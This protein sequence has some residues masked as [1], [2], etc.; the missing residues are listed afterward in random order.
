MRA[1]AIGFLLVL[2][3]P[4]TAP[5][6]VSP[7]GLP[8]LSYMVHPDYP[9]EVVAFFGDLTTWGGCNEVYVPHPSAGCAVMRGEAAT[10]AFGIRW[11]GSSPLRLMPAGESFVNLIPRVAPQ[12]I[13]S[14][15]I[16]V[17]WIPGPGQERNADGSFTILPK[18]GLSF[19]IDLS[20]LARSMPAGEYTLCFRPNLVP[21]GGVSWDRGSDQCYRF[22]LIE[23]DTIAAQLELL[24]RKAVDALADNDCRK[25]AAIVDAMLEID[26]AS[27]VAY[28]IRAAV[29]ELE[30][31]HDVA[32]AALMQASALLRGG[33]DRS[34]AIIPEYRFEIAEAL[35]DRRISIQL[36]QGLSLLGDASTGYVCK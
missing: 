8:R 14:W 30:R 6:Q 35:D 22:E 17:R 13:K 12:G 26:Q 32:I 21:Q 24:R 2:A 9:G 20:G 23:T 1:I 10:L 3:A 7:E 4:A 15:P 29:A 19:R 11:T 27:A 31:R 5:T 18:R 34:L 25:T 36:A 28:R 33:N 16:S